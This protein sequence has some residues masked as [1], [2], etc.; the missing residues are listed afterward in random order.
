MLDRVY[1]KQEARSILRGA[2][3]SPYLF[4]LLYLVILFVLNSVDNYVFFDSQ[5]AVLLIERYQL[6]ISPAIFHAPFPGPLVTFVS[7]AVTL[8]GNVLSGGWVLYHQGIRRGEYRDYVTLFDG[9]AFAGKLILLGIVQAAL[10]FCWSLLFVIPG[11]IATYRYRFALFILCENP[12]LSA[13]EALRLS[14]EQTAGFKWQLFLLDLSF[15]GWSFLRSLTFD[16][17]SIWIAPYMLQ[18]ELGYYQAIQSSRQPQSRP[19]GDDFDDSFHS[20]S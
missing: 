18:T 16:I 8:L 20:F 12:E 10:V 13:L 15:L 19:D 17:L 3:V 9:F 1:L 6:P 14:K 2:R 5:Q 4:T 11:I 7:V